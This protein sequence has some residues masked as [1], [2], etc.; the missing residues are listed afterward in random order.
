VIALAACAI[1]FVEETR[2]ESG[3]WGRFTFKIIG[4]L[5]S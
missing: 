4:G 3:K 1:S 5:R 2:G